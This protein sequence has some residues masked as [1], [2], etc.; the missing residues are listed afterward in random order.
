[1]T[2]KLWIIIILTFSNFIF[3]DENLKMKDIEKT[4]SL[5]EVKVP[6][7]E[8]MNSDNTESGLDIYSYNCFETGYFIK[9]N[10]IFYYDGVESGKVFGAD[11]NTFSQ[12]YS[13]I[14]RDKKNVYYGTKIIKGLDIETLKIY[15]DAIDLEETKP[16]VTCYP[17]VDI[18][19]KD[20]NGVYI[21]ERTKSGKAR[22]IKYREE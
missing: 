7:L 19:L 4:Y 3:S 17:I 14:G 18:R 2:K 12:I 6:D 20:K 10:K 1:M 22:V 13:F 15:S 5:E 11:A 8:D 9:D 21:L 16:E